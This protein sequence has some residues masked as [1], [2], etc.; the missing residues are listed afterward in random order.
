MS[1]ELKEA[2]QHTKQLFQK[3]TRSE[4]WGRNIIEGSSNIKS[5]KDWTKYYSFLTN[6]NHFDPENEPVP[7]DIDTEIEAPDPRYDIIEHRNGTD[8]NIHYK[9]KK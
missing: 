4:D 3:R 8:V 5:I 6:P 7:M 9:L 1:P 2:I